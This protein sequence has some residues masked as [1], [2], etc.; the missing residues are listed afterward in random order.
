MSLSH[1]L[2][3]VLA[4][5][6]VVATS[7]DRLTLHG[8]V[9]ADD[10][11]MP[12]RNARVAIA[13]EA[14]GAPVVLSD[15][16]GRFAVSAP[17]GAFRVI[18]SKTGY[19]RVEV[20]GRPDMPL[21]VRLQRGAS[22]SGRIID[23]AGEPIE[24][25][26]LTA[27]LAR[28]D[29]KAPPVAV[30]VTDDRGEYRL[31]GLARGAY[32]V[33]AMVAGPVV[34]QRIGNGIAV[35]PRTDRIFFPDAPSAAEASTLT[36]GAGEERGRID[37][38]A[39]NGRSMGQLAI[40]TPGPL[41]RPPS[42]K[43]GERSTAIVR[44][45]VVSADGRGIAHA[46]VRLM[47]VIDR[48]EMLHM[49]ADVEGTFE[50]RQLPPG[51]YALAAGKVGFQLSASLP[52]VTVTEDKV[53]EGIEIPLRRWGAIT[54]RVLDENG[55][56]IQNGAVQPLQIHF[57]RGRRRLVAVG[58]PALSDDL[59]R[60]RIRSLAAGNYV[61]SASV[62]EVG[63]AE[64]PNYARGF[65][66]GTANAA[67][68]QF[69][70][71]ADGQELAPID[72]AMSRART[73][74][75]SGRL[76][77]SSGQPTMGGS[78]M[79]LPAQ[80]SS[81]VTFVGAGARLTQDGRFEFTNVVDGQYL[82]QVSRNRLNTST[83]GEF[84]AMP[85]TVNGADVTGLTI[86]TSAGSSIH[87]RVSFST[88]DPAKTPNQRGV[89]LTVIPVDPDTAPSSVASADL[90]DDWTFDMRG[91]NGERRLTLVR[92]PDGWTL[93][94]VR[95]NGIDATDRPIPFGRSDQ[96]LTD[97][98]V[99]LTDRIS[100]LSG[101]VPGTRAAVVAFT[102][103][104]SRWYAGTR[105]LRVT[106]VREGTFRITG[107]PFGTYYVAAVNALP[108]EGEDAWQERQFLETLARQAETI[109]IH[110]GERTTVRFGR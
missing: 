49:R 55:D 31:A 20:A 107:L 77:D 101:T 110:D 53:V 51:R 105:F 90:H 14:I 38:V 44:G 60:Y 4:A 61:V 85:L 93:E 45:R 62:A 104:R 9:I 29:D 25:A 73:A 11:G 98:E 96:S 58:P 103:D 75:I 59:G 80:S 41:N 63:S 5:T 43:N 18:V 27:Q 1:L 50:F 71:V 86:Q 88:R 83:E 32:V 99:V 70:S 65:F 42:A 21:D 94:R 47:S 72:L 19:G 106:T 17:T 23:G 48:L 78:V 69:V 91:I 89:E 79:L 76:L 24:Y 2:S 26:R 16:D 87:G 68:A 13:A 7:Q 28:A 34:P 8:R 3:G 52:P 108:S 57:E 66:P 10:S 97:V 82:I 109:T 30:T 36:L 64:L 35:I 39:M 102:T 46:E 22:I 12:I 6:A 92:A 54:G 37:F 84:G 95:V 100:E 67:Q 56:P 81:S 33:A 74:R 40:L 15:A